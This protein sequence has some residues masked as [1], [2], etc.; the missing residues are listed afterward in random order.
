MARKALGRG[1]DALIPNAE[2]IVRRD[3]SGDADEDEGRT[4][5]ADHDARDGNEVVRESS[6]AVAAG[7][8]TDGVPG[9]EGS[10]ATAEADGV[11]TEETGRDDGEA[12]GAAVPNVDGSVDPTSAP[13]PPRPA[14]P[15]PVSASTDEPAASL[16]APP[17]P[18]VSGRRAL[19]SGRATAVIEI[20]LDRIAPNPYQPR[21][22]F[23]EEDLRELVDSIVSRG[24]L[25]PVLVRRR[26]VGYEL[27][28]GERRLRAARRAGLH[29]IPAIV[30]SAEE[31]DMLE[32]A[33][34]ENQQRVDLNPIEA[35]E[36]FTRAID[37]F[38]LTVDELATIVGKDR[39]TVANLLRLLALPEEVQEMVRRGQLDMGHARALA[40]VKSAPRVVGLARRAVRAGL[41]VRAV[42]RL[43]R[44]PERRP[45]RQRRA[46]P[47]IERFENRLRERF[48]TQARINRRGARGK[49]EI[50]FYNADDLE[51]ILDVLGVLSQG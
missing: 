35:A 21:A 39:S 13:E 6:P 7:P 51:R 36:A 9:G 24:V 30:R 41:S 26:G 22:R 31:S 8:S 50:E 42:E 32:L 33:I 43:A 40:G 27:I 4:T 45:P 1:L 25:Q 34:I 17:G 37:E 47:E 48:G 10:V 46:D 3:A 2:S 19:A 16:T 23:D 18:A 20:A 11:S 14:N 38:G 15:L 12:D 29:A 49:I 28:A 44:D 5:P